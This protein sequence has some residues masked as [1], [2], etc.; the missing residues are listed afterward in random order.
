MRAERVV[1]DE[2]AIEY[3]WDL[4]RISCEVVSECAAQPR[5]DHKVPESS[6]EVPSAK[7]ALAGLRYYLIHSAWPKG[8]A[9]NL[10]FV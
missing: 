4:I 1:T 7:L 6:L 5:R 2:I 10:Y 8:L 9:G 3:R